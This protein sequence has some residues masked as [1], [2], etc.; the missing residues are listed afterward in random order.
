VEPSRAHDVEP[1]REVEALGVNDEAAVGSP[2][3]TGEVERALIAQRVRRWRVVGGLLVVSVVAVAIGAILPR[4][5]SEV[6]AA[7]WGSAG[8]RDAA[9][10]GR[11]DGI[12][13]VQPADDPRWER[14]FGRG[15]SSGFGDAYPDLYGDVVLLHHDRGTAVYT[16]AEGR[17]LLELDHDVVVVEDVVVARGAINGQDRVTAYDSL[18]GAP[19]WQ[20]PAADARFEE[21]GGLLLSVRAGVAPQVVSLVD[22][23]S[24]AIAWSVELDGG[25]DLHDA[26]VIDVAGST[27]LVGH[28]RLDDGEVVDV[29]HTAIAVATGRARSVELGTDWDASNWPVLLDGQTL[30]ILRDGQAFAVDIAT[31]GDRGRRPALDGQGL[32]AAGQWV[33]VTRGD[34]S[35]LLRR[36][37]LGHVLTV[38]GGF[39]DLGATER[40]GGDLISG[41]RFNPAPAEYGPFWVDAATGREVEMG[42]PAG[43][44]SAW[45]ADGRGVV[46]VNG[47]TMT[48]R[49]PA[50]ATLWETAID[51]SPGGGLAWIDGRVVAALDVWAVAIDPAGSLTAYGAS[52]ADRRIRVPARWPTAVVVAGDEVVHVAGDVL[53]GHADLSGSVRT[54]QHALDGPAVATAATADSVWVATETTVVEVDAATGAVRYSLDLAHVR[55]LSLDGH[56]A[57]VAVTAPS[58]PSSDPC[59]SQV[60][61][62]DPD[63]AEV[64]WSVDVTGACDGVTLADGLVAVPTETGLV[65]LDADDGSDVGAW[66]VERGACTGAAW[67]AG[68][69]ILAGD[70][71]L[72]VGTP[73]GIDV[74][75]LLDAP[76]TTAAVVVGDA[77]VLVGSGGGVAAVDLDSLALEWTAP[78][79]RGLAAPPLVVDGQL[80]VLTLDSAVLRLR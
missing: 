38:D 5:A 32:A 73:S 37:G 50:G 45:A 41:Y 77:Q 76:A 21:H 10:T 59:P 6:V 71:G 17:R 9:R 12:A 20:V 26:W 55:A 52:V 29:R 54:W 79:G 80:Y 57:L 2:D 60:V 70:G 46:E 74:S 13:V 18:T 8:G 78:A 19:R 40:S 63:R 58:C 15:S 61:R 67:S 49:S 39:I 47:A 44:A 33:V 30:A 34:R 16:R 27:I 1:S 14:R 65:F 3:P 28:G 51:T 69:W 25:G 75:V 68:R 35:D 7:G 24:G 62:A 4:D 64:V 43:P 42:I 48:A 23:D 66:T 56:G 22:F 11:V 31:E 36:A 53:Q 72:V